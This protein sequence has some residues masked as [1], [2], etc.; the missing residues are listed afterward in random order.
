[1]FVSATKSSAKYPVESNVASEREAA[2]GRKGFQ[3]ERNRR[4]RS[5][6]ATATKCR[7]LPWDAYGSGSQNCK[8]F[9]L[10]FGFSLS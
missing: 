1:D 2:K 5:L 10:G 6:W 4:F 8:Y 7:D 3:R 9:W